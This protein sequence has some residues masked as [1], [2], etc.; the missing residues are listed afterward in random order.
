MLGASVSD[1]YLLIKALINMEKIVDL[2]VI[3]KKKKKMKKYSRVYRNC[4]S[5]LVRSNINTFI[6]GELSDTVPL[7]YEKGRRSNI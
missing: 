1:L 6:Q 3:T 5:G 4:E 7:N 2:C